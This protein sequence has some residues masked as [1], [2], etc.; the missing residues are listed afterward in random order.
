MSYRRANLALTTKLSAANEKD[1][2]EPRHRPNS[3]TRSEITWGCSLMMLKAVC[4][5]ADNTV[6]LKKEY[7]PKIGTCGD[8][9]M[10]NNTNLKIIERY[11]SGLLLFRFDILQRQRYVASGC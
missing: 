11:V 4:A 7:I 6:F 1:T 9:L 8:N 10:E 2:I 5:E 3:P